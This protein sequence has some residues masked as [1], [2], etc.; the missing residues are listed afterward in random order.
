MRMIIPNIFFSFLGLMKIIA[1]YF[2]YRAIIN[3]CIII[4]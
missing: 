1:Q 2:A 3:G 4:L